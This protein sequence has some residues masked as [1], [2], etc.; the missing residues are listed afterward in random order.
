MRFLPCAPRVTSSSRRP[1]ARVDSPRSS[2]SKSLAKSSRSCAKNSSMELV[3]AS[4]SSPTRRVDSS[5]ELEKA[6]EIAART[7]PKVLGRPSRSEV[8]NQ[9]FL[10][11]GFSAVVM[12]LSCV[13]Q[14]SWLAT[15]SRKA[16][17]KG[18]YPDRIRS[19][20]FAALRCAKTPQ[21]ADS[22]KAAVTKANESSTR[23]AT[24]R[25]RVRGATSA[26]TRLRRA[27]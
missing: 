18:R 7:S 2:A 19:A 25:R 22:A 14:V 13:L 9:I 17:D 16:S 4:R 10:S 1:S 11:A 27:W 24:V 21:P 12:W 15:R 23:V 3:S 5:P 20:S 8:S 26:I 6:R